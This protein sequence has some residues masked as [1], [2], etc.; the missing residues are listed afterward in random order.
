VLLSLLQQNKFLLEI[1]YTLTEENNIHAIKL[2][3]KLHD[4]GVK[5]ADI[6]KEIDKINHAHHHHVIP[7]WQKIL[8]PI[9]FWKALIHD[10]HEA[11]R[12]KYEPVAIQRL[13]EIFMP[14]VKRHLYVW[15]VVYYLIMLALPTVALGYDKCFFEFEVW[16]FIVYGVYLVL[17]AVWEIWVVLKIQR[18]INNRDLLHFNKWHVVELF[19][20]A[21]ART[22]T[23]IDILFV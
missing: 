7:L 18:I 23:F 14:T 11:F 8:F 10:K 19:M 9:W 5:A 2:F 22:D 13:E 4:Q 15:T 6:V 1:N 12:F 17:C 3:K 20:G 16:I 21:I